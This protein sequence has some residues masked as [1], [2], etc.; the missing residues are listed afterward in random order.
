LPIRQ[1]PD[2]FV[3]SQQ[4]KSY[5][6]ILNQ[7]NELRKEL[8]PVVIGAQEKL[9]FN[10]FSV[11]PSPANR[12][13]NISTVRGASCSIYNMQGQMMWSQPAADAMVRVDISTWPAGSYCVK[14]DDGQSTR[15]VKL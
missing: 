5:G 14:S 1:A 9:P 15:F 10:Q 6:S 2:Q 3:A 8:A 4:N 13:L 11:W 7:A 12:E